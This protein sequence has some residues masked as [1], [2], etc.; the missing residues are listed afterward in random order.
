MEKFNDKQNDVFG[1]IFGELKKRNVCFEIKAFAL[2]DFDDDNFRML[3][4]DPN[5]KITGTDEEIKKVNERAKYLEI[6]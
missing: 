3:F 6:I 5:N 2:I 1:K 4:T